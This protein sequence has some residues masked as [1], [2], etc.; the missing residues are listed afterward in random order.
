MRYFFHIRDDGFYGDEE[1]MELSGLPSAQKVAEE[2]ARSVMI[3]QIRTG[4]L[5]LSHQVEVHDEQGAQVYV[6][7]FRDAV[8]LNDAS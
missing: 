8:R 1:G 3:Q 5:D 4:S 7:R 6:L 2:T